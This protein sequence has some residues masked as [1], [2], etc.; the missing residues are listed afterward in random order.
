MLKSDVITYYGSG[1]AAGAAIGLSRQAVSAWPDLIPELQARRYH[2]V[3]RGRK[4]N[5]VILKFDPS[6]YEQERI[7]S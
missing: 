4:R 2:D 6:L 3:T 1:V 5:G 7:A